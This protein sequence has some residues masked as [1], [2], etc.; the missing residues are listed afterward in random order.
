M[1]VYLLIIFSLFLSCEEQKSNHFFDQ[2][3]KRWIATTSIEKINT[4][5]KD[6]SLI[7][8]PKETVQALLKINFLDSNFNEVSDC[9]FY[10]I[11]KIN[12]GELFIVENP[13]N[14]SCMDL[15]ADT[16]FVKMKNIRNF[17][18]EISS[19][20]RLKIDLEKIDYK[21]LNLASKRT[22][23]ILSSSS[24]RKILVA[25]SVNYKLEKE[26]LSDGSICFD[27]ND[28]C[29]ETVKDH[30]DRCKGSFYLVVARACSSRFQ[31][32]CGE[33]ICGSKNNPACIRGF[34][35]SGVKPENYCINDSPV[36]FCNTG[37]RV[38]CINS[39]LMC[40]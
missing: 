13:K 5:Y 4:N 1:Y 2:T 29:S 16:P 27:I 28:E 18:I 26:E 25:S 3:Q 21:L 9:L 8:S 6:L 38:V 37:L 14:V 35:T 10:K 34:K 17:G 40:Q 12:E 15:V 33:S 23:K 31:K 24:R 22:K 20:L 11:P 7:I 36:G 32:R 39:V 19:F 30:C